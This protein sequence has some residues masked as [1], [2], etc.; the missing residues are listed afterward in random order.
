MADEDRVMYIPS[1][2]RGEA[3][4]YQDWF[5][6]ITIGFQP[7][8]P[9]TQAYRMA[10]RAGH[11]MHVQGRGTKGYFHYAPQ[12][13][14]SEEQRGLMSNYEWDVRRKTYFGE[15]SGKL[16][17]MS[18]KPYNRGEKALSKASDLSGDT[19]EDSMGQGLANFLDAEFG[20]SKA[21]VYEAMSSR[22]HQ[23]IM[24][25]SIEELAEELVYDKEPSM[26]FTDRSRALPGGPRDPIIKKGMGRGFDIFLENTK[27]FGDFLEDITN[28]DLSA[29][30]ILSLEV[31]RAQ[32][33]PT[34][35]K[36]FSRFDKQDLAHDSLRGVF[37][38]HMVSTV[39]KMNKE[40]YEAVGQMEARALD[41]MDEW[42]KW[43]EIQGHWSTS[44][45]L[46]IMRE[47]KVGTEEHSAWLTQIGLHGTK[48]AIYQWHAHMRENI[49]RMRANALN[50]HRRGVEELSHLWSA[51]LGEQ[52][53]GLA[54]LVPDTR[55][56]T[57]DPSHPYLVP[58]IG[59]V[60]SQGRWTGQV[61][62]VWGLKGDIIEAYARWMFEQGYLSILEYAELTARAAV[63]ASNIATAIE[64]RIGALDTFLTTTAAADM[65]DGVNLEVKVVRHMK[66]TEIAT[67]L[68]KQ[69]EDFYTSGTMKKNLATWYDQL[70]EESER[71]TT[72]WMDLMPENTEGTASL[73]SEYVFGDR[74]GNPRKKYL[75]VWRDKVSQT[76][77]TTGEGS[78]G[79]VG[80]NFSIAPFV[81]SRRVGGVD[82]G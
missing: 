49:D 36:I 72:A 19:R 37:Q 27:S 17:S 9:F 73:A 18:V 65:V 45:A 39:T 70:M 40:I 42:Q 52:T 34:S 77:K 35:S 38:E 1:P 63:E 20:L 29:D 56:Y 61:W 4:Q 76:W 58:Q 81:T 8:I 48:E 64:G 25:R 13:E 57:N 2:A 14:P 12:D 7:Y 60:D 44:G 31:S 71:L 33:G 53:V 6:T 47:A 5:R 50:A 82:F 74:L 66:S 30:G 41:N 11:L 75:G 67:S 21:P 59:P 43:D 15:G 55:A 32:A 28:Q 10:L 54:W 80:Y 46:D 3:F 22:A 16:T 24:L 69:L 26:S 62:T 23:E 68:A 51:P 79:D 78:K